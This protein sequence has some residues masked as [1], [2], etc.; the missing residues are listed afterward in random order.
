MRLPKILPSV[1]TAGLL[2]ASAHAAQAATYEVSLT[3]ATRG[4]LFTPRLVVTHSVGQA[5]V[6]GQP[7]LPQLV[8]LAEGGATQ[9]FEDLLAGF[10]AVIGSV[11]TTDGVMEAGGTETI[12]VSTDDDTPKL[13]L[14]AMVLPSNDGFIALNAVDLPQQGSVSYDVVVYDAGSESNDESCAHIPGPQCGGEA[15]SPEDSGEGYVHV[16]AG[17][18]GMSDLTSASYDW[19]NP[20]AR[21]T[22]TRIE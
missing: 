3:N 13:S 7:A 21:V 10:P 6:L 5:F 19:R 16:H 14:L 1:V 18:H 22:I 8:A 15:D 4:L 11:Q 12:A 17:I 2:A 20:A 9:P